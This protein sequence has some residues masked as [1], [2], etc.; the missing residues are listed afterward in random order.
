MSKRRTWLVNLS[1]VMGSLLVGLIAVEAGLRLADISHPFPWSFDSERGIA[2]RPGARGVWHDEGIATF[3]IN[4]DGLRDGEHTVPKPPGV[5]R[6]AVL[7]DS[8]AEALQVNR[9][10]TFWSVLE[11]ELADCPALASRRV[12]TLNFG[13]SGYSTGQSL[14]TLQRTVWRYQPD[15]VLLAFF[16]GNDVADNM[17]GLS[18]YARRPYFRLSGDVL[19]LDD[20][21]N[22]TSQFRLLRLIWTT[23]VDPLIDHSRLLQLLNE[24]RRKLQASELRM[25]AKAVAAPDGKAKGLSGSVFRSPDTPAWEQAWA[26]TEALL[27]TMRKQV[28]AHGAR[29]WL[30]TLSVGWQVHPDPVFRASAMRDLGI[31]TAFYPERRLRAFAGKHGIDIITLAEPLQRQAERDGLYLHGFQN[32]GFGDGHWNR[33]GHQRAGKLMADRLC[34][35]LVDR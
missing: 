12:E 34:Q 7:G 20:S 2:L 13:V 21:F 8:F 14:I 23:L 28:E 31:E 30:T 16:T 17:P 5:F 35:R 15:I 24:T 18:G 3:R 19:V 11:R 33:D 1:V 9:E 29:F 25:I 26:I 10:E 6:I 4:S 32:T 22:R 27:L